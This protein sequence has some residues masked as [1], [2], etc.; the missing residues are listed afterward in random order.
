MRRDDDRPPPPTLA[1]VQGYRVDVF[2]LLQ[3]L[4]PSHAVVPV[5]VLIAQLRSALP[6]PQVH[7]QLRCQACGSQDIH[8]RSNWKGL[9]QVAGHWPSRA[10]LDIDCEPNHIVENFTGRCAS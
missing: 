9:G 7:G 6:S 1:Q 4:S 8:A 10:A 3:P 5:A 2:L